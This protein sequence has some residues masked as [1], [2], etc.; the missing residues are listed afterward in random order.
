MGL[1]DKF[2]KKEDKKAD[3]TA[4]GWNAITKACDKAYPDQK[5]PKHYVPKVSCRLG[6]KD[7]LDGISVYDG[8][9]YC[10]KRNGLSYL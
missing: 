1:F 10:L 5:N 7:Q 8:G 4:P 9:D 3:I 6:G 2:R